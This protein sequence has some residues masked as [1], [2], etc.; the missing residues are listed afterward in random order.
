LAPD[1]T[2]PVVL[3]ATIKSRSAHGAVPR[4]AVLDSNGNP[5]PSDVLASGN[6][7]LT[8]QAANLP[9]GVEYYLKVSGSDDG[10]MS[11]LIVDFQQPTTLLTDLSSGTLSA[12]A[13]QQDGTLL[14]GQT[15]LFHLVLSANAGRHAWGASVQVTITD[16]N[17]NV[18]TSLAAQPGNAVSVSGVLLTAGAYS[19]HFTLVNPTAAAVKYRLRIASITDPLG[20]V[21]SDPTTTPINNW[22]IPS[23]YLG[24][25]PPQL[26]NNLFYWLPFVF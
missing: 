22:P 3:T 17:G 8:I 2:Q 7:K 12:A 4:A 9:A 24:Y 6:G 20:P 1:G 23:Q 25:L 14:V 15:Q 10:S 18:V 26:L 13:P 5:V 16:A 11:Q 19:V 21:V